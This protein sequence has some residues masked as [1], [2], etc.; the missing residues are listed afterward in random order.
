MDDF[1]E[2]VEK[3]SDNGKN[4]VTWHGEL[5]LSPRFLWDLLHFSPPPIPI[6]F[7]ALALLLLLFSISLHYPIF[8][9]SHFPHLPSR[10]IALFT[11]R[12]SLTPSTLNFIVGRILPKHIRN[13][14]IATRKLC[15]VSWS[16]LHPSH[17]FMSRIMNIPRRIWMICGRMFYCTTL[18]THTIAI[19]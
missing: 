14:I 13:A 11:R 12:T 15:Y 9:F 2:K 10:A 7:P 1:F 17:P 6:P 8:T 3:K 18:P 5:V 4:L 19:S 16:I